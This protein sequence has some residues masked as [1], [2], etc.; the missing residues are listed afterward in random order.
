[1]LSDWLKILNS[2]SECSIFLLEMFFIGSGAGLQF[3]C[4]WFYQ[5][6]KYVLHY[7]R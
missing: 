3:D 4:F 6:G 2:Q 7:S 5:A 1:M